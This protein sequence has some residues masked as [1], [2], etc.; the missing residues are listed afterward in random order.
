VKSRSFT[1]D[2]LFKVKKKKEL[3]LLEKE[4]EKRFFGSEQNTHTS[5]QAAHI[6]GWM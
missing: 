6:L 2:Q 5:S 4:R 1:T 3:L